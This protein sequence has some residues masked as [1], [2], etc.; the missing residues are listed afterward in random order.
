M[1]EIGHAAETSNYL[2]LYVPVIVARRQEEQEEPGIPPGVYVHAATK[3]ALSLVRRRL[4]S[5]VGDVKC[6]K[7]DDGW[8][9]IDVRCSKDASLRVCVCVS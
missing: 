6:S 3:D 2:C 4:S 1:L 9:L 7:D 8:A 5:I